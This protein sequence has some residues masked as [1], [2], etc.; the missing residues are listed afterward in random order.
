MTRRALLAA[1]VAALVAMIVIVLAVNGT[2][3][4]G[5]RALIRATA[6]SS[7]LCVAF[8]V[9]RIRARELELA[10]PISHGLHFGAIAALAIATTPANAHINAVSLPGGLAIYALMLAQAMRPRAP[11]LYVLWIIFLIGF[12]VGRGPSPVY[13]G[14]VTILLGAMLVRHVSIRLPRRTGTPISPS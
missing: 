8:A 14:A 6:R 12:G 11:Q 2:D 13:A 10:L 1:I 9:A 7:A 4:A 5:L 3:E